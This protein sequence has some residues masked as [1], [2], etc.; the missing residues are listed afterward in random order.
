MAGNTRAEILIV[1]LSFMRNAIAKRMPMPNREAHAGNVFSAAT[2]M[3]RSPRLAPVTL[4]Y[5][6][7]L[8]KVPK[9]SG[10]GW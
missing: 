6:A 10:Y 2:A 7:T 5:A 3:A 1:A 4:S 9:E 8:R